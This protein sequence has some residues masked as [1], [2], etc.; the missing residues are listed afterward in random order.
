MSVT[1]PVV[2]VNCRV[3]RHRPD[4]RTV[5]LDPSETAV[6]VRGGSIAAIG[7]DA[8]VREQASGRAEVIDAGGGVVAPGFVDAHVHAFDCALGSL[9][10]SLL[11]PRVDRLDVLKRRLA[12]R[13]GTT[14][15]GGWVVGEGYDDMRL[16]ER[17][18]PS[19]L[20]LDA[21]VPDRPVIVTRVC[22]HMSV[23]NSRALEA[24]G[25]DSATPD[26]PGG[27][28]VRDGSGAPTGLLLEEAQA[29]VARR[30]PAA[31]ARDI[32]DALSGVGRRLLSY[33]ITSICEALLGAFHPSEAD[34]WSEVLRSDWLGPK[35]RFLADARLGDSLA[36]SE[37]PVIGTKLFADG[38]VTGGTAA[39]ST[40]FESAD[41]IG[42]LIHEPEELRELV[43]A[44]AARALPVGIHAM[45][46]RGIDVSVDAIRSI[47]ST[48]TLAPPLRPDG[49]ALARYRIEHCSLPSR[50]ALRTM[51]SLG[52]VPVPQPVFLFAEGE[53][54]RTQ[55]G[56]ER[57]A[58]AYPLRTM[59]DVGLRPALSSDAPAT[60]L[61][62]AFDPWYGIATATDRRTWAGSQLGAVESI[63]T[64]EAI[65]C[66]TLNGAAS[67]SLA[68][69]TGSIDVGKS[70]DLIVLPDD[71]LSVPTGDLRSLR[72][73]LVIVDGRIAH[74][75]GE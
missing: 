63:S 33:G 61:E 68:D 24:V 12:D 20:D 59:V 17:R 50:D 34:I 31:R 58:H 25:I 52:I 47:A 60:S 40:P 53:G 38:V 15:D 3:L 64:A 74:A 19:R 30:V 18:H 70:A 42:M 62:D 10:V 7:N 45:G 1:D 54:Y 32:A 21:A 49:L 28:I 6:L 71:P 13:A 35:V 29:L 73:R 46:D 36:G 41:G 22:G 16:A 23:A 5:H 44:S 2:I 26:P 37:L 56:D 75:S 72:P 55:L 66:Y 69:R 51:R 27:A 8:D 14:P 4:Q 67:M 39:V 11:P 9:K 43:R 65:A 57:C 48:E